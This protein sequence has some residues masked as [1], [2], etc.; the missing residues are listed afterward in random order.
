MG[1]SSLFLKLL[2]VF[3]LGENRI[4]SSSIVQFKIVFLSVFY[5]P[6]QSKNIELKNSK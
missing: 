1:L 5:R 2:V 3:H 4:T 6:T